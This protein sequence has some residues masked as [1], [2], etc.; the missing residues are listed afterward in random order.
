[1][2]LPQCKQIKNQTPNVVQENNRC[3]ILDPYKSNLK[4]RRQN[5]ELNNCT[6]RSSIL[7][8]LGSGHQNLHETYQCRMYSRELLTMDREDVRNM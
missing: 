8:L 1:L 5:G 2:V 4:V 7:T 6:E 3:L